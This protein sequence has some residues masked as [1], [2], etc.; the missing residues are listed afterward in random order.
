MSDKEMLLQEKS[1]I[2]PDVFEF[3]SSTNKESNGPKA[4]N[5]DYSLWDTLVMILTHLTARDT[6]RK[7]QKSS[8]VMGKIKPGAEIRNSKG[9]FWGSKFH[10]HL[11]T[12]RPT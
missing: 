2:S 5:C 3:Y 4:S 8:R 1:N 11:L 12:E 6:H 9:K 10:L 7:G